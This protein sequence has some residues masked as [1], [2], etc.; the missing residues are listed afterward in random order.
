MLVSGVQ[1]N[2]LTI[3]YIIKC[4]PPQV[5][6]PSMTIQNY[7]SIIEYIS[8]AILYIP[9]TLF[10]TASLYL[11]ILYLFCPMPTP[12]SFQQPPEGGYLLCLWVCFCSLCFTF[13]IPHLSDAMQYLSLYVQLLPITIMSSKSVFH[14]CCCKWQHF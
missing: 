8:S 10:I 9:E 4:S 13:Q 11:L 3:I 1:H 5:L 7:Y 6:L 12:P 14:L 2:D